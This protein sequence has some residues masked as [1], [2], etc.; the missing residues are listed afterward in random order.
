MKIFYG[1]VIVC[2][3]SMALAAPLP[4]GTTPAGGS[5]SSVSEAG[6]NS[7]DPALAAPAIIS[8]ASTPADNSTVTPL[9]NSPT[10]SLQESMTNALANG[11]FGPDVSSAQKNATVSSTSSAAGGSC[12]TDHTAGGRSAICRTYAN[13][14][15]TRGNITHASV[16]ALNITPLATPGAHSTLHSAAPA[17]ANVTASAS[18]ANSTDPVELSNLAGTVANEDIATTSDSRGANTD[19]ILLET[20]LIPALATAVDSAFD[21]MGDSDPYSDGAG[22]DDRATAEIGSADTST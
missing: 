11:T 1:K 2:V 17:P 22:A 9:V 16:T 13:A 4:Q 3:V 19:A 7:T 8:V 5:S 10:S 21:Y 15:N 12:A 14:S 6:S 20:D 18:T